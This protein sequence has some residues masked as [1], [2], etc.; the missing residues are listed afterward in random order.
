MTVTWHHPPPTIRGFYSPIPGV[1][2]LC[3]A[4][5]PCGFWVATVKSEPAR[6]YPLCRNWR[7]GRSCVIRCVQAIHLVTHYLPSEMTK[8]LVRSTG[9][10]ADGRHR[11]WM[12]PDLL[13]K[14]TKGVDRSPARAHDYNSVFT[15]YSARS[16]A[17]TGAGPI[18]TRTGSTFETSWS[19]R[20]AV[21]Q[22]YGCC[23]SH[24][25]NSN[26]PVKTVSGAGVSNLCRSRYCRDK[27]FEGQAGT[28]YGTVGHST[29]CS[30]GGDA[31]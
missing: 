29:P 18:L 5:R 3:G 4:V 8:G 21:R 20:T 1:R 12:Y 31:C 27:Y 2:S 26:R 23:D 30:G 25:Q 17:G 11:Y 22:G 14:S 10:E 16:G 15:G 6:E 19:N 9:V 28:W 7:D 13:L 24:R